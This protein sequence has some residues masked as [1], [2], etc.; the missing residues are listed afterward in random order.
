MFSIPS[1]AESI[2]ISEERSRRTSGSPPVMRSRL[3][4]IFAITR[5][6]RAISS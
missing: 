1:M 2:R 5:T 4:P 6:T 3:S